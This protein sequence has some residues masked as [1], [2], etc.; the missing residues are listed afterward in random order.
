[1]AYASAS[2][3]AN[4]CPHLLEGASSFSAST[5]P[6]SN[7]VTTWLDTGEA[8][9]NTA[10]A[11]HGY[12]AIGTGSGVYAWV[13]SINANFGAWQAERSLL[14]ARVSKMENTR[15]D[16]F[17]R[18]FNDG[19]EMLCKLDLS[20]MGIGRSKAPPKDYA[21]GISKSDKQANDDDGD[22]VSPRFQRGL[23]RNPET[24]T[25]EPG[26]LDKQTRKDNAA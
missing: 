22:L 9:I 4:L 25:P 5:T 17:K 26:K 19:L 2:D 8:I 15:S 14:S 23:F 13:R 7:A 21:G 20:Q 24:L 1:M 10:L 11:T 16:L 3:V 12:D 18:D 6:T